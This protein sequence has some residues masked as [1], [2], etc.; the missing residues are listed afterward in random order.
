MKIV[1]PAGNMER[2]Y[3]SVKAGAQEIYMGLKGFGAR[4]NAENFTLEEYKEALDYAH[5][6]G[7]R[8]FLTLNTIM[9]E[10]EMDFLYENLKVL[11]EHGLDAVI[12]QDLGYFRYMKENFPDMEYHGSTQMTVGNH[13]EA[14]YL[15]KIG[16]KRVVLPREMTFEEIK[17][18][19]ENTSI[20]LE[21]FVS[22]AL[23]ICYSGK[24]SFIYLK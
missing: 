8:I 19:R 4:R 16:F 12:V 13:V 15:R 14:E 10:K 2:F 7:V 21:I 20:E 24:F 18:I 17:K 3:A 22:G 6:R 11:Y 23:C 5:K 9:M 1:A